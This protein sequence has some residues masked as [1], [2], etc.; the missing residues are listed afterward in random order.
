V[1]GLG[2]MPNYWPKLAELRVPVTLLA[3]ALDSKF[4]ALSERM[5]EQLP[6]AALELVPD[7]GHDLLLERPQLMTEVIRRGNPT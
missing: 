4:T 2:E 5:A 7:A 1:T 3:G 6:R